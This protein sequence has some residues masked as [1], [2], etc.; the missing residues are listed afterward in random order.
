MVNG[1]TSII[2]KDNKARKLTC[3]K[4]EMN[5]NPKK[6]CPHPVRLIDA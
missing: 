1:F 6:T 5:S 3:M 4:Q 2:L